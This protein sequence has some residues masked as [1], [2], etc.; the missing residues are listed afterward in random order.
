VVDAF[1]VDNPK[2]GRRPARAAA[3]PLLG[4]DLL[5]AQIADR[6]SGNAYGYDLDSLAVRLLLAYLGHRAGLGLVGVVGGWWLGGYVAAEL[7][8]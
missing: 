1:G 8:R 7:V 2:I 6:G 4:S 3:P 5:D